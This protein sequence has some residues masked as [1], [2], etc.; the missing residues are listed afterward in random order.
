MRNQAHERRAEHLR[1]MAWECQRLAGAVSDPGV[2]LDLLSLAAR[3]ERLAEESRG[4]AG[5]SAAGTA[6][7]SRRNI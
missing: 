1:D 7:R 5:W 6:A 2:R 4:N 3:F